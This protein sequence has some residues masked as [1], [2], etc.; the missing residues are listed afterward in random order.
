MSA[1]R[2][3]L[4]RR[5]LLPFN[6]LTRAEQAAVRAAVEPLADLPVERWEAAGAKRLEADSPLYLVF[7]DD[8]L[9]AIVQPGPAGGVEI[10]D[11]VRH[12][13]LKLFKNVSMER[14]A[15]A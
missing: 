14:T 11:L 9:R 15:R 8:S 3:V 7:V 6:A 1:E 10:L 4:N 13:A 12:E 5:A 2:F